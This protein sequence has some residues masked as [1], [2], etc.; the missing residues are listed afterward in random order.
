M[1]TALSIRDIVLI[2]K[3]D[4]S[5]ERGL[6]VLTGETG[7][8]K[9]I[10]LDALGLALGAR[11]DSSLVRSGAERGV[12]TAAFMLP[13]AHAAFAIL[14]EQGIEA[15]G[16][17]VIRRIQNADGPSRAAINDQPVSLNLLR[18]IAGALAEIH[19]QHA[20]RALVD[21]AV[22]RRL[23]DAFGGL[24]G[25]VQE[26]SA[27]WAKASAA[28]AALTEHRGLMDRAEAEREY[29]EHA[30]EE[31]RALNPIEGEEAKLAEARQLMMSAE[32]YAGALTEAEEALAG[33]GTAIA[34]LNA[35]LR[36]L[37]RRRDTAGGRLDHVCSA[38]DRVLA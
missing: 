21:V 17:L 18:Q 27:L 15:N 10:L 20:D 25:A 16:E 4:I 11:G 19:G 28:E 30:T 1:L 38:L 34:R 35:A 23:L 6:T 22:H 24:D 29:L 3:L 9:S 26:V 31:L 14:K 7:A 36:K 2:E 8:G 33:D 5:L 37:E 13:N 32:Q 12:V